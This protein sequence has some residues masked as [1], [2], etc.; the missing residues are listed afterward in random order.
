MGVRLDMHAR[1]IYVFNPAHDL[2]GILGYGTVLH[3][4]P[5]YSYPHG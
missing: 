1:M 2:V 5:K 4:P 3:L